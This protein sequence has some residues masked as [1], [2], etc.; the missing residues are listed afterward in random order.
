MN[1]W[2]ARQLR[3]YKRYGAPSVI[4]LGLVGLWMVARDA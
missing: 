3:D 1:S 4:A 2:D